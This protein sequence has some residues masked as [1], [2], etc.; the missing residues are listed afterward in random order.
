[1][2]K[3]VLPWHLLLLR[4]SLLI[5]PYLTVL[6]LLGLVVLMIDVF[7]RNG[8]AIAHSRLGKALLGLGLLMVLGCFGAEHKSEA[9][10]QLANYLPLFGLFICLQFVLTGPRQLEQIAADLVRMAI[11]LNLIGILEFGLKSARKLPLKLPAGW[12]W[13]LLGWPGPHDPHRVVS[14]FLHPNFFAAY[15]ILILGLGLGLVLKIANSPLGHRPGWV[16][17]DPLP[18]RWVGWQKWLIFGGTFLNLGGIFCS[19]SRNAMIVALLQLLLFGLCLKGNRRI[20]L[21]I[22]VGL[23]VLAVAVGIYG[24]GGRQIS[25]QSFSADP[26]LGVWR[27]SWGLILERPWWGWGMGNFKFLYPARIIDSNYPFIAHPHN[28]WLLTAVES[29]IPAMLVFSA[30]VGYLC[31]RGISALIWAGLPDS[32]R[33]MLLGYVFAFGGCIAFALFDVT[34]FDIR[35]NV[36]NWFMLAGIGVF[37][38]SSPQPNP[39]Y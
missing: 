10:L 24:L 30:L 8:A 12:D 25:F 26:R 3:S 7:R 17:A 31:Y 19:G 36:L 38:R 2:L 1:M 20:R 39:R 5:L 37:S 11:P 22:M 27:I 28:F 16:G 23:A 13:Q 18:Q 33:A 4:V 15:L 35:I 14:L 29:G 34:L 6:S 32:E 9:F 21:G